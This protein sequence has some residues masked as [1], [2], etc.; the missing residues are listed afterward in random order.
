MA[1]MAEFNPMID[2][3]V[4]NQGKTSR[5]TVALTE[6][7]RVE[8]ECERL[9]QLQA[10]LAHTNRVSMMGELAGSL[11]H[12]IKQ[13]ITAAATSAQTTLL[14]LQREP[15]DIAK[16]RK[17][18]AR[19]VKDLIRAAEII[20][21]NR[22]L[23]TRGAPQRGLVE[24]NELIRQIIALLYDAANRHSIEI[25][26]ELDG[27]LPMISADPVQ[28]QQVLMNLMLNGIEAM[29][30]TS[31]KLT[32]SS[33]KTED[34]QILISVSDLG[35]GLPIENTER[36]FDAFFTTKPR[37]TGMGLSIS[38]RIIESHGGRLWACANTGLGATFQ[39]TLPAAALPSSESAQAH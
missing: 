16:A 39:F 26:A 15:P 32:V 22:S 14:W 4:W 35:V 3:T 11:A 27:S 29:T 23:Y 6:L 10:D 9:L 33:K 7:K 24:P 31:G 18:V 30:E 25:R 21:R 1:N 34:G 2:G 13:P 36:I 5:A 19:I 38:H 17:A 12:E 20:D 28:L 37:G 8:E